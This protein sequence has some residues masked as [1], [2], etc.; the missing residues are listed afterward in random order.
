MGQ[1][2]VSRVRVAVPAFRDTSGR[3]ECPVLAR[4]GP[5]ARAWTAA[6]AERADSPELRVLV[7]AVAQARRLQATVLRGG[8]PA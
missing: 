8:A 5:G 6:L 2:L 1:C 3:A 4:R 7:G